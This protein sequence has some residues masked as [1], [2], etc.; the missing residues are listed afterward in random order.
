M[1]LRDRILQAAAALYAETGYRGATTRRIAE[2]AGVNEIT[3]F[4]HFGSKTRLLHEAIKC[5]AV[6]SN[7]CELTARPSDP[8]SE[9]TEWARLTHRN[10]HQHAS[11]IR[12]AMA[13]IEERP[14]F[15]PP[16]QSPMI[17]AAK[18]LRRYLAGLEEAG[19]TRS[20]V[21]LDAA[22][23][24]LLGALFVDGVSRDILPQLFPETPEQSIQRYVEL[25]LH[26]LGVEE[27][28]P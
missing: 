20:G 11:L 7:L 8:V 16:D 23:M 3:L 15:M 9:L 28:K 21:D 25:F 1:E 2:R 14:D 18:S 13:E 6:G 26:G 24:M 10:L 27:M 19:R 17:W 12:T 4:R 22:T 5:A